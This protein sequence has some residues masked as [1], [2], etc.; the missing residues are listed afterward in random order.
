[1]SEFVIKIIFQNPKKKLI[2][3]GY[4][5]EISI[6]NLS[7][8]IKKIIGFKGKIIFDKNKPDGVMRK[9]LNSNYAKSLGFKISINL[10]Q[11][12]NMTYKSKFLN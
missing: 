4:G 9:L 7:N 6:K 11:G 10:E 2:N 1:M 12:L 3:V 5:E 8:L